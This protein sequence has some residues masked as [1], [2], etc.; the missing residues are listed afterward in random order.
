MTDAQKQIE[1]A[2]AHISAAPRKV[3]EW[4][5]GSWW[6]VAVTGK[7]GSYTPLYEGQGNTSRERQQD[8]NRWHAEQGA[9]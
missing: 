5:P 4:V 2:K 6:V 9:K 7:D 3:I 1:R 8:A